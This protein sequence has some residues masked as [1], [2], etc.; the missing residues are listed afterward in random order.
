[1]TGV[2]LSAGELQVL[3]ECSGL[4]FKVY[5]RLRSRMDFS[6]GVVGLRS[7]MSITALREWGEEL[8]ERGGGMQRVKPSVQQVR[9]A[10]AQLERRGLLRRKPGETL[11]FLMPL[12]LT[13]QA[14]PNQTQQEPNTRTQHGTQHEPNTPKGSNGAWSDATEGANPTRNIVIPDGQNGPNSTHIGVYV[15]RKPLGGGVHDWEDVDAATQ[16]NAAAA[17]NGLA[18]SMTSLI[19]VS[20][21]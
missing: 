18:K 11:V 19:L 12:A 6:T 9:T 2:L 17:V 14:R 21:C 1:M 5:M 10:L 8:I 7:G 13:K 3:H 20:T 4:A 16:Q 15:N